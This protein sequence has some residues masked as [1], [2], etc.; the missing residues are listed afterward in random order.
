MKHKFFLKFLYGI[1][2]TAAWG[3]TKVDTPEPM[4]DAGNII[5][6]IPSEDGL[7][8]VGINLK[9]EPQTVNFV[10]VRRDIANSNQL[11]KEVK[12][13]LTYDFSIVDEYNEEH[14]M[15]LEAAPQ[16]SF[17]YNSANPASGNNIN[18][19]FAPG[20]FVKYVKID[21]PDATVFD[22]AIAYGVGYK[23]TSADQ[24]AKISADLGKVVMQLGVKNR[25]DGR[26]RVTGSL[27]DLTAATIT[28]KSPFDMHLVTV[29]ANTV[30]MYYPPREEYYHP[31]ISAGAESVYGNFSVVVK[32]GDD[33]K[34]IS[35]VN[36][37]GQGTGSRWGVLDASGVNTYD[38]A[39]KSFKIKYTMNQPS[40]SAVRTQFDETWTYLGE[41]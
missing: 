14:E 13:V 19:T 22:P 15:E 16:G 29:D 2:L 5:V 32:I 28:A 4:G 39:T 3:C 38:P 27:V 31:I 33:N 25:F 23:I 12:V 17:S 37:W 7:A 8:V 30:E 6:K 20:E 18:L 24:D 11:N 10:E 9:A 41:R 21:V 40:A 26:Y 35:V 1:I 36:G 34:V